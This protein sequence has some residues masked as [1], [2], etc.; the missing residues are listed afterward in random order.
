[1]I[2]S[3]RCK[4]YRGFEDFTVPGLGRV[5]LVIGANNSGKSSLLGAA[6]TGGVDVGGLP[7]PLLRERS[8]D[9]GS[10][11]ARLWKPCF[12]HGDEDRGLGIEVTDEAGLTVGLSV[13]ATDPQTANIPGPDAWLYDVHLTGPTQRSF[14]IR[15]DGRN[16]YADPPTAIQTA[17]ALWSPTSNE[18]S[19]FDIA[20]LRD[21]ALDGDL[22]RVAAPLRAFDPQIEGVELV[23]DDVVV[24]LRDQKR[25]LPIS[26]LGDGAFRI[27]DIAI[28]TTDP[29]A[30]LWCLD[31]ADATLHHTALPQLWR[32]LQAAPPH[33]QVFATTHRDESVRAA[34]LAFLDANDDGLR[35]VRIDREA[36]RHTATLYTAAEAQFAIDAGWEIR[37]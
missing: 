28:C 16:I 8:A 12:R 37:G 9:G 32:M 2:T 4:N 15:Y 18:L 24:R 27:L 23:G 26:I 11:R 21:L 20:R 34:A 22:D 5:N 19:D 29:N 36:G 10:Q 17:T 25:R 13:R 3:I 31:E 14:R 33:L 35:I 7:M 1:M 30:T 6:L